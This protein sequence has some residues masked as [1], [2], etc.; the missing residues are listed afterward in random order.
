MQ[1]DVAQNW[2]DFETEWGHYVIAA[3]LVKKLKKDNGQP[4]EADILQV[5][6]TLCSVMGRDCLKVMNSLPTLTEADH[7]NPGRNKEELKA[8][9]VP[10]RHVLFE[11]YKFNSAS[12][13]ATDTVDCYLVRLRQLAESC[14]FGKHQ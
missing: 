1:G 2:R 10:Q 11:R 8:H 4:D 6:S 14:K 5:A 12:Q 3:Q 9:F 13:Q 7:R